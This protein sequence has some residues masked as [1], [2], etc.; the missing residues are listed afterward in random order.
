M[1]SIGYGTLSFFRRYSIILVIMLL[2]FPFLKAEE[3]TLSPLDKLINESATPYEKFYN[4]I[5]AGDW[6]LANNRPKI[7]KKYYLTAITYY[8]DLKET[9]EYADALVKYANL[10]DDKLEA[11]ELLYQA[12]RILEALPNTELAIA[13]ILETLVW[14]YDFKNKDVLT[15]T[16]L[17]EDALAIRK[18]YPYTSQYSETLRILGWMYESRHLL[19]QADYYYSSALNQDLLNLGFSDIRTVL[20]MENLGLFYIDYNEL[21]KAKRL[22]TEKLKLHNKLKQKDYYNIGRTESMLGWISLQENDPK[23]A[24]EYYINALKHVNQS[25]SQ[26]QDEP[27]YYSISAL[28]DLIMFYVSQN[29]YTKAIPYYDAIQK[30]LNESGGISVR[31]YLGSMDINNSETLSSSYPWA[32]REQLKNMQKF[33]LFIAKKQRSGR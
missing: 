31:E 14:T 10:E 22:L 9:V 33:M 7:A 30:V 5:N 23:S 29:Q 11:R 21:P 19:S 6:Y 17:L 18:K 16:Q 1:V 3:H 32:I 13:N 26:N 27:H 25:L 2:I 12:K 28:F 24:E 8:T 15:V 4:T 20:T